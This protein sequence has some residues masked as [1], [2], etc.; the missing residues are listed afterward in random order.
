MENEE[1][2]KLPSGAFLKLVEQRQSIRKFSEQPVERE[3][4]VACIEAARLA[5]SAENVQPWRFVV[6]DEPQAIRRFGE[7]AFSGVYRFSRWVMDSPVI[8]AIFA[9]LDWIANRIGKQIQ[10]TSY[11]LIDIGIAGEH[12]VLQAEEQ[13]LG[14]C[15]IGWFDSKKGAKI[16]E[17]PRN[18][19]LTALLAVGYPARPIPSGKAKKALDDILFFN[20]FAG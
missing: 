18:W 12:I 9:N 14:S 5:P 1:M 10:G 13:G 16:L 6:L 3:K 8:I 7:A 11:Y 17:A 2:L 20:K 4:I 15:W 19:K